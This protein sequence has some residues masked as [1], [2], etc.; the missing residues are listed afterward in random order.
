MRKEGEKILQSL[1]SKFFYLSFLFL[2]AHASLLS[3][4]SHFPL[5]SM[6]ID[7][8]FSLHQII[9]DHLYKCALLNK[10]VLWDIRI[11]IDSLSHHKQTN[12]L[13]YSIVEGIIPIT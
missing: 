8:V 4:Q 10:A 7:K 11:S 5:L 6:I 3:F 9:S 2:F 12:V 13:A 1:H